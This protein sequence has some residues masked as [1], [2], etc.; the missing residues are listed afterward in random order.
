MDSPLLPQPAGSLH[1]GN[2]ID[3]L[4]HHGPL[5]CVWFNGRRIGYTRA[6]HPEN[7]S[8]LPYMTS[9]VVMDNQDREECRR[10]AA[11]QLTKD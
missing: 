11:V 4:D 8:F 6:D 10:A 5:Y 7:I 2:K 9:K 1:V 3:V